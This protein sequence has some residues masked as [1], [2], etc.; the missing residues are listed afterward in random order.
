M[1]PHG[2]GEA[3][4]AGSGGGHVWRCVNCTKKGIKCEWPEAG[5]KVQACK[6]CRESKALCMVG[7]QEASKKRKDQSG[8]SLEKVVWKKTKKVES[9]EK[10]VVPVEKEV[11]LAEQDLQR[12]ILLQMQVMHR[13]LCSMHATIKEISLQINPNWEEK[14]ESESEEVEDKDKEEEE[15]EEGPEEETLDEGRVEK[16]ERSKGKEREE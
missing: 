15:L 12:Q 3:E 5:S 9:V 1:M 14:S 10:E 16:R 4:A 11:V 2:E 8:S 7:G 13:T 6:G